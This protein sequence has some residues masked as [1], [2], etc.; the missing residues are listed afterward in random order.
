MN[1]WNY[2]NTHK[3]VA[4]IGRVE[5][6]PACQV[7][8]GQH[9]RSNLSLLLFTLPIL[10]SRPTVNKASLTSTRDFYKIPNDEV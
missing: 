9:H 2:M 8:I 10:S 5:F 6:R 7:Q 3:G 4:P 1:N